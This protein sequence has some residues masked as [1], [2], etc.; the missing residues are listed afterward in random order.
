[1]KSNAQNFLI[2]ITLFIFQYYFAFSQQAET[3]LL[4]PF[5]KLRVANN[6]NLKLIPGSENKAELHLKNI[7]SD[8]VLIEENNDELQFKTKGIFSNADINVIVYYTESIK[9][10]STTV[11]GMVRSDSVLVSDNLELDCKLDGYVNIIIDV[12]ELKINAGQG[13][14]VYVAGKS[15]K[16]IVDATTGANVRTELLISEN[17]EVKSLLG[18]EV[19]LNVRNNF[20]AQAISGGK[21]YYSE[22]PAGEFKVSSS[23]G[24]EV[25]Q[26]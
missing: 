19:W 15:N 17:A 6:I 21:I 26:Q 4:Q 14:D 1:M 23:T 10:I 8:K 13:A 16:T 25:L 3:R 20:K 11:G 12:S 22:K 2:G 18:A 7:T 5:N 9:K 24:G